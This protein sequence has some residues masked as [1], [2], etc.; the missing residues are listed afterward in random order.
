VEDTGTGIHPDVADKIFDPFFTTKEPGKGTGLGLSTSLTIVKSH[1]GHIRASSV[2]GRGASFRIYLPVTAGPGP[3]SAP[4]AA[5]DQPKGAGETVLVVDDEPAIRLL[6]QRT[7]EAQGYR[8]LLAGDGAEAIA[9]FRAQYES[10]ALVMLDMTM[11]VLDGVPTIQALARIDP[12]VRIIASSGIHGNEQAARAASPRVTQ[13][14]PKPF[15]ADILLRAI[16]QAL[17]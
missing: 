6:A 4:A 16:R 2:P 15:T 8:V 3:E 7:L 17:A 13:F 9:I 1:G 14:M 10:I 12:A 11:P 5:A